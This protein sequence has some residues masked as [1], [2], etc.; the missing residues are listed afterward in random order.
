MTM[1][2]KQWYT[3]A[4]RLPNS[5]QKVSIGPPSML[6]LTPMIIGQGADGNPGLRHERF[7]R[8]E[9]LAAGAPVDPGGVSDYDRLPEG[10]T[11]QSDQSTAT[12]QCL[13]PCQSSR[14]MREKWRC[15]VRPV[16]LDR[17]GIG[18]RVGVPPAAGQGS[19]AYPAQRSRG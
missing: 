1:R 15:R 14:G 5:L 9:G 2:S 16:L 12:M 4:S 8:A 18:Q 7:P 17:D 13:D 19:E 10:R 11:V 6:V 3:K